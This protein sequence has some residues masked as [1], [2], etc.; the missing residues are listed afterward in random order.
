MTAK[1]EFPKLILATIAAFVI[2]FFTVVGLQTT[3]FDYVA[4]DYDKHLTEQV[5]VDA[6]VNQNANLVFYK[7]G[8][9]Y[10]EKGKIAVIDAAEKS[11][12][13]TFYIDVESED[14]QVLV[15][16]YQVKHAAS[17]IKIRNGKSTLYQYAIEKKPGQIEANQVTIKEAVGE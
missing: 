5:Y 15:K 8:C 9:P 11:P 1:L 10:C 6:V 12:Y 17:I 3:W 16:K 2:L 13:P 7:K 14:G 4:R